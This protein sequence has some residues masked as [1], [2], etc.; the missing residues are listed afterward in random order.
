MWLE[1]QATSFTKHLPSLEV[2]MFGE[3]NE[4]KKSKQYFSTLISALCEPVSQ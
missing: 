4:E 2:Q 1:P 3:A